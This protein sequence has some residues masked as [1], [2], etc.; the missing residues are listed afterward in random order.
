M[1]ANEFVIEIKIEEHYTFFQKPCNRFLSAQK[2][3]VNEKC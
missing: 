1:K 2:P 3:V